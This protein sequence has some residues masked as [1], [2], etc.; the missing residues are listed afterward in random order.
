MFALLLC[1]YAAE[2]VPPADVIQRPRLL[3]PVVHL[4][5]PRT[6]AKATVPG[7]VLFEWH[8]GTTLP[9]IGSWVDLWTR[10]SSGICSPQQRVE[11]V[12]S[13][14]AIHP[15][16]VHAQHV[17]RVPAEAKDRLTALKYLTWTE[18][19]ADDT[20]TYPSVACPGK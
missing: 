18:R 11:V 12:L 6:K 9:K 16:Q 2:P 19:S 8:G 17:L 20:R 1:A 4:M 3:E 7:M 14:D 13:P 10:T 15:D 5:A